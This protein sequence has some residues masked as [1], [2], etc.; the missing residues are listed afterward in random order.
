MT[1][2]RVGR[3]DFGF[4]RSPSGPRDEDPLPAAIRAA[5]EWDAAGSMSWSDVAWALLR[6]S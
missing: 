6:S 3:N 1:T 2:N 4:G 5:F